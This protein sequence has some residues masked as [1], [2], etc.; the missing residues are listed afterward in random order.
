MTRRTATDRQTTNLKTGRLAAPR[1]NT[2]SR[3]KIG[4]SLANRLYLLL[5]LFVVSITAVAGYNLF[6]LRSGLVAQKETELRHLADVAISI[7][8]VRTHKGV[9]PSGVT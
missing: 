9:S 1:G 2:M 6:A 8:R 3:F 7:A 4:S 5:A